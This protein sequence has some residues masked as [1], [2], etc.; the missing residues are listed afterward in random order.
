MDATEGAP[1]FFDVFNCAIQWDPE[2]R[3]SADE[4]LQYP[5]TEKGD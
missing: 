3:Q 2:E 1:L 4:L 5:W